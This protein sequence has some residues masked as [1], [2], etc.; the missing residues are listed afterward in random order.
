MQQSKFRTYSILGQVGL[1]TILFLINYADELPYSSALASIV[2]ALNYTLMIVG[3]VYVHYFLVF[4]LYLKKKKLIYF[5]SVFLLMT[6]F[7][8]LYF[9][10]DAVLPFDPEDLRV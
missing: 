5:V 10:V 4:P 9:L 7:I 1:W 8:F 6:F 3:V 2:F